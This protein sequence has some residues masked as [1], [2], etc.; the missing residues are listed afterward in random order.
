MRQL[1][2]L[3]IF[4]S[5]TVSSTVL[6]CSNIRNNKAP[7]AILGAGKF[8]VVDSLT[9]ANFDH[10]QFSILKAFDNDFKKMADY[11]LGI[12]PPNSAL[13]S[14]NPKI[15]L[16][17]KFIQE[18]K[19]ITEEEYYLLAQQKILKDLVP[20]YLGGCSGQAEAEL[21]DVSQLIENGKVVGLNLKKFNGL[22]KANLTFWK[23]SQTMLPDVLP[24]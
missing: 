10:F 22:L 21:F 8:E 15:P 3:I 6:D 5:T 19:D 4:Y 14:A 2:F 24:R 16:F 20:L 12:T 11:M 17:S 13:C 23:I 9:I 1:I 7:I 18:K